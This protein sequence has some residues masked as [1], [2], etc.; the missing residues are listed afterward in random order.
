MGKN[1]FARM[2]ARGSSTPPGAWLDDERDGPSDE[3]PTG[4]CESGYR[5]ESGTG[6]DEGEEALMKMIG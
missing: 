6:R 1:G 4:P 5:D 3:R 2:T